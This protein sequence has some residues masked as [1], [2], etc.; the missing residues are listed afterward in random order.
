MDKRL[1][2][3]EYV[4]YC[5]KILKEYITGI[6]DGSIITNKWIKLAVKLYLHNLERKDLELKL[7][8]VAKVLKFMSICNLNIDNKYRQFIPAPYQMFLRSE[9]HTSE[10]QSH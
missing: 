6:Q 1:N 2:S 5:Y 3:D 8:K 9:E 7:E 4:L 10:L